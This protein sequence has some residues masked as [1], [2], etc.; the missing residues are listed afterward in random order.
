MDGHTF[1]TNY[2]RRL[3]RLAK[4]NEKKIID[5]SKYVDMPELNRVGPP[6]PSPTAAEAKDEARFR[7]TKLGQPFDEEQSLTKEQIKEIEE[8]LLSQYVKELTRNLFKGK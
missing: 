7:A 5:A 2:Q 4:Q 8:K 1:L 3:E 6:T